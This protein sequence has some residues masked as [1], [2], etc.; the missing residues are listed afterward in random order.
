M[1]LWD[2]KQVPLLQLIMYIFNYYV[3]LQ[4]G[5]CCFFV[6]LHKKISSLVFAK[7]WVCTTQKTVGL[8]N[9]VWDFHI[10]W[11][12]LDR[13]HILFFLSSEISFCFTKLLC[14]MPFW[15]KGRMDRC[16][17]RC[18]V[19]ILYQLLLFKGQRNSNLSRKLFFVLEML[20]WCTKPISSNDRRKNGKKERILLSLF[21]LNSSVC[22]ARLHWM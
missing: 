6:Q 13:K 9:P 11:L 16:R 7:W 3:F 20:V 2:V 5:R 8:L 1:F 15:R 19:I 10:W 4:K 14:D 22:T 12:L 17:D 21:A 18:L